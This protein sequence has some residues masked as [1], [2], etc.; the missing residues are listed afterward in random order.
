MWSL[1]TMEY[2]SAPKKEEILTHA[3][4]WMNL[5]GLMLSEMSQSQKDEYN[6]IPF[7][8]GTSSSGRQKVE[9]WL[10]EAGG[11][12]GNGELLFHRVWS[13]SLGR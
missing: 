1:H 5:E 11:G 6:M 8:R 4:T 12:V 3:T 10:P 9:W 7:I 13:F 2:Y